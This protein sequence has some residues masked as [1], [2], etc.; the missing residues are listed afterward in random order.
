MQGRQIAIS[1]GGSGARATEAL[2]YLCAAGLGPE[3]LTL[4][5]VDADTSNFSLKNVIELVRV[6]QQLQPDAQDDCALFRTRIALADPPMWTPFQAGQGQPKL[7]SYFDYSGLLARSPTRGVGQLMQALYTE[8]HRS[9]PL[10]DGFLGKP[11]IGAAILSHSIARTQ[12]PWTNI[13]TA[14]RT[15]AGNGQQVSVFALGSVFGGTGAAGL[16][17]IPKLLADSVDQGKDKVCLGA[18]LLLPYF[19]F[20]VPSDVKQTGRVFASPDAFLLNSKE[21]LRHYHSLGD[22]FHRLYLFGASRLAAQKSFCKGG[23]KQTNLPHFIELVAASGATDFFRTATPATRALRL[24]KVSSDDAFR[25]SDYPERQRDRPALADLAR[26]CFFYVSKVFPRLQDV[27]SH[28]AGATRTPWYQHLMAR[29]GVSLALD[30]EWAFCVNLELFCKRFLIWMRDLQANHG[31]IDVQ[32]ADTSAIRDMRSA[33][34][35]AV[36]NERLFDRSLIHDDGNR[37]P[38]IA[39][40]WARLCEHNGKVSLPSRRVFEMALYRAA[41]G[42]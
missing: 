2:L 8:D 6:Y 25:W 38:R 31:N 11:S 28:V 20:P 14:M 36:L 23:E 3:E 41:K 37:G 19:S 26:L 13:S 9:A 4:V 7:A 42:D 15:H 21:S 30:A 24:A 1:I 35:P 34:E 22:L 40:M 10:D 33:E 5:F 27:R 32:L 12:S 29:R 16:P 39:E 18:A 17:T